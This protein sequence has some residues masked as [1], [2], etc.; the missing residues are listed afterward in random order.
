[1]IQHQNTHPG[2]AFKPHTPGSS[3][4]PLSVTVRIP[5]NLAMALELT[6]YPE[7]LLA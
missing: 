6:E 2:P 7:P 1:M 3:Y 4:L 5:G